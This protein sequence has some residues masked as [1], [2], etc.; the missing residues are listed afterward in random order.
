MGGRR[1]ERQTNKEGDKGAPLFFFFYLA[2]PGG[3]LVF[4][5]ERCEL[6]QADDAPLP[7]FS[8]I[9]RDQIAGELSGGFQFGGL[10]VETLS[11]G[12]RA[13]P[14]RRRSIAFL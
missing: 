4:F 5:K 10:L 3:A 6:L 7:C 12:G 2:V 1:R 11:R 9:V 8:G 13:L 14:P